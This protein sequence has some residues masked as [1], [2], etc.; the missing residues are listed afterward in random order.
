MREKKRERE[1]DRNIYTHIERQEETKHGRE[2]WSD[3]NKSR[4]KIETYV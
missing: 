3:R 1:H 4:G 2:T